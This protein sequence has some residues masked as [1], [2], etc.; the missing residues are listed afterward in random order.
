LTFEID[1]IIARK[2]G[3]RTQLSNL[4]LA[5][6][7]CNTYK[8]PNVAGVAP[9][10]GEI[11]RLFNPRRDEWNEHFVWVGVELQGKTNIGEATIAVLKINH[12]EFVAMREALLDEGSFP[13]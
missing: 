10:T 1:H 7:Y 13:Y 9:D 5:C 4:A 2:H 6:Y 11:V 12:P 3:G 8:G